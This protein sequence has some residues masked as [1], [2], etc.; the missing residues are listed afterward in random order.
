MIMNKNN[1][2]FE[3]A[4]DRNAQ[5]KQLKLRFAHLT[6]S[7]LKF[8]TGKEEELLGRFESKLNEWHNEMISIISKN[9]QEKV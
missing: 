6:I 7:D 4:G 8:E 3:I 1:G 2:A 5:S 9:Q